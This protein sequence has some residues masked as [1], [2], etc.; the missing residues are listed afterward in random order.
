MKVFHLGECCPY[1]FVSLFQ[2]FDMNTAV[3]KAAA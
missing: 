1:K 2:V 3:V